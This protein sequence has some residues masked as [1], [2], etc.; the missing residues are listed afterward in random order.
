MSSYIQKRKAFDDKQAEIAKRETEI[1]K[2]AY[3]KIMN[4]PQGQIVIANFLELTCMLEDDPSPYADATKT[5]GRGLLKMLHS[6]N[7][8]LCDKILLKYT[9]NILQ[10]QK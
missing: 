9:N 3:L 5:L 2:A 8:E 6:L 7:A 1:L 10:G 4:D